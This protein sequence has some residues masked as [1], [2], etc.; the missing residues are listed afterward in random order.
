MIFSWRWRGCGRNVSPAR[1]PSLSFMNGKGD[2]N[3]SFTDKFRE[4]HVKIWGPSRLDIALT[5][6]VA[7]KPAKKKRKKKKGYK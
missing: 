6:E 2:S 5:A 1:P 7:K 4:G 3:R